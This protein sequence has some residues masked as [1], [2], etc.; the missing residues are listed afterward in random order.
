MAALFTCRVTSS[1]WQIEHTLQWSRDWF[2]GC[3]KQNADE[4]NQYLSDPDYTT[5]LNAQHNTKLDTLSRC[6]L[7]HDWFAVV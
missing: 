4:V 1:S 6:V 7:S 3:F 2:E 5:Y